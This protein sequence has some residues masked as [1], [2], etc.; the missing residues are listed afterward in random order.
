MKGCSAFYE[1]VDS[2]ISLFTIWPEYLNLVSLLFN[3]LINKV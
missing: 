3:N 1:V 2:T